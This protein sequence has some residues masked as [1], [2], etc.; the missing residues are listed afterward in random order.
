MSIHFPYRIARTGLTKAPSSA[1]AHARGLIEQVLFTSPGERVMRPTFGTGVHQLVFAAAGE[2]AATAAQQ[3]VS[4][5]LQQWLAGWI[6]V[7]D[8]DVEGHDATLIVTVR[9]RLRTTGENDT[10]SFTLEGAR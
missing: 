3:L 4:G 2:Q 8:V 10:V 7:Q 6:E 5:A 1:A 9:Y